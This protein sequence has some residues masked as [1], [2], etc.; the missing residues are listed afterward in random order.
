MEITVA[1]SMKYEIK[2]GKKQQFTGQLN[3]APLAMKILYVNDD[4]LVKNFGIAEGKN[5]KT[6]FG[7]NITLST[8]WQICK[9]IVWNNRMYW[10]SNFDYHI[11]E[12]ENNIN[13]TVTK[14]ITANLHLYPR[15]DNSN[16]NY[17][18]GKDH[19]GTYLMFKELLSLGLTYNF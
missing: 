1:P 10:F 19:D 8:K 17:R 18:S 13:F 14:L 9:Q 16:K 4:E 15:F 6:T 11:W 7:P 12:W 3:I 2:W 5:Q